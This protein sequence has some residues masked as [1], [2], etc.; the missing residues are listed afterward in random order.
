MA[1]SKRILTEIEKAEKKRIADA[2]ERERAQMSFS[3]I[4]STMGH[5]AREE[6]C[7]ATIEIWRS[8]LNAFKD[9]G[10]KIKM[11]D[12]LVNAEE[13]DPFNA[14]RYEELGRWFVEQWRRFKPGA[15][16]V[17]V[18]GLHY[19]ISALASTPDAVYLP[20]G[21]LY[22]NTDLRWQDL[23]RAG[24]YARYLK[25]IDPE[26]FEDRRSRDPIVKPFETG[27][28]SL[29]VTNSM[30]TFDDF[31]LPE[32]PSFPEFPELPEFPDL[33]SYCLSLKGQQRYRLEVWIEKSTQESVIVPVCTKH[34]VTLVTA[35]GEISISAMWK[36]VKRAAQYSERTTT[37][38]LYISD[39]DPAGQSMPVA[40]ARKLEF[41]RMMRR[42]NVN[43]RLCPIALTH[44]QC[45]E[46]QLP[47]TPIKASDGKRGGFE[48]RYGDGA[49]ELDALESLHPG[50]LAKLLEQAI[51][52]FR[53]NTVERR[54]WDKRQEIN[55]ELRDIAREVHSE[56]DMDG[57]EE[58]YE[59]AKEALVEIV[60]EHS[61][62]EDAYNEFEEQYDRDVRAKFDKWHSNYLELLQHDVDSAMKAVEDDLEEKMPNVEEYEIPEAAEV[63]LDDNCLYD[64]NRDYVPQLA[65]YKQFAG[66]FTHLVEDEEESA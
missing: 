42:S 64:S 48:H 12:F 46:Y 20:N 4:L 24:K 39:F 58:E 34:G 18:R 31:D 60:N 7:H 25:M 61:R 2:K 27:H 57:L 43:I 51:L 35:Q 49:T 29:W 62:Y 56:H 59:K 66:K 17:H 26:A 53:D 14:H 19:A 8:K 45:I 3:T 11:K 30:Y 10:E 28:R 6:V 13:G 52:R 16:T 37:V 5:I 32:F 23:Q 63:P 41:L 33:P 50:E 40:A 38:I 21:T 9:R 1:K 54:V 65:V 44:E 15:T 55:A 47:R 36:A 22:D